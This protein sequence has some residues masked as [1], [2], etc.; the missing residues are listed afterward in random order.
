VNPPRVTLL[1][2]H[3][4]IFG[5]EVTFCAPIRLLPFS[6]S[7]VIEELIARIDSARAA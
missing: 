1:L 4:G 5:K 7:P 6:K 3:P 2:R